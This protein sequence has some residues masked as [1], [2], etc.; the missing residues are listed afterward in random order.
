MSHVQQTSDDISQE[1]SSPQVNKTAQ[2]K[3]DQKSQQKY[4]Y[5]SPK[6]NKVPLD[7]LPPKKPTRE[8][9]LGPVKSKQGLKASR[10]TREGKLGTVQAKQSLVIKNKSEV[11]TTITQHTV[12]PGEG[13]W[14]I[15]KKHNP[16]ASGS[17]ISQLVLKIVELNKLENMNALIAPGQILKVPTTTKINNQKSPK[18]TAI[19]PDPKLEENMR[20]FE[21]KMMEQKPDNTR[22]HQP[23]IFK[24]KKVNE[25][26][27]P[28]KEQVPKKAKKRIKPDFSLNGIK[29]TLK[30]KGYKFYEEEGKV[31]LIAVRMDDVF[32][33]KFSDKLF[34]IQKVKG[35]TE[36]KEIPWTTMPGLYG[37]NGVYDPITTPEYNSDWSIAEKN[38]TGV[39][40][41]AEGQYVDQ[42]KFTQRGHIG[43]YPE[44]VQAGSI[45]HYR[46]AN[47]DKK[48]DRGKVYDGP[49]GWPGLFIHHM[50]P[51]GVNSDNVNSKGAAWS[52]GC[53]GAPEPEFKKLFP[54]VK[55]HKDNNHGAIT[56][57]LLHLK[58]FIDN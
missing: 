3:P 47:K 28:K 12:E 54:Y 23:P 13:L 31:N 34:V 37:K 4:T 30:R 14:T 38:T 51:L 24:G 25:K 48:F 15:A 27:A 49:N 26:K 42:Y 35:K 29:N 58:D 6:E 18:K 36:M 5:T 2:T 46:D 41:M 17:E 44:L 7:G 39:A 9:K 56:Y 32:D 53:Q 10:V 16:K 11:G 45:K 57:T 22:V 33:N 20:T 43:R 55:H 19:E 8:N 40:V 1:Q 52:I 50:S 21:A